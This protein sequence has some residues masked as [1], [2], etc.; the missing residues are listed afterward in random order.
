MVNKAKVSVNAAT[1]ELINSGAASKF[2]LSPASTSNPAPIPAQGQLRSAGNGQFVVSDP[3]LKATGGA[4]GTVFA[5]ARIAG[6]PDSA[7]IYS[8]Q[9]SETQQFVTGSPDGVVPLSATAPAVQAWE[10]FRVVPYQSNYI[11][12][13]VASG[14]AV[15]VQGD[16]TLIDNDSDVGSNALWTIA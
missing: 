5:F 12:V 6:S 4:S 14:L 3:Q 2:R 16:N 15:A 9:N 11:I 8:I 13:H 10:H 1:G 7:P